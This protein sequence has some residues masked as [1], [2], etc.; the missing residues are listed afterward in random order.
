VAEQLER[1]REVMARVMP[2]AAAQAAVP[3][4]VVVFRNQKSFGP[5]RMRYDGKPIDVEGFFIGAPEENLVA[6][7]LEHRDSALRVIFHEYAHLIIGNAAGRVPVWLNEGLADYYSTFQIRGDGKSAVRGVVVP[8][9]IR[10]LRETAWLRNEQLLAVD[11]A[12]PLYNEGSRRS[13]L[14]AQSWAI[15]HFLLNGDTDRS[16][17]LAQYARATGAGVAPVEAWR[18]V[19]PSLDLYN[20]LHKHLN[21]PI[22]R[23]TEFRFSQELPRVSGDRSDVSAAETLAVLGDVL[24]RVAP[25]RETEAHLQKAVGMQPAAP[26]AKALL[27][28]L[29]VE[30][31]KLQEAKPLLMEAAGSADWLTCY[32]AAV[33]LTRIAIEDHDGDNSDAVTSA[34]KAIDAVLAVRPDLPYALAMR[35][36]LALVHSGD[37]A[38]TLE[39]IGG[40]R[41]RAPGREDFAF[42][43]AQVLARLRKFAQARSV[44]GPF[45][46]SVYPPAVREYAKSLMALVI[47][48]EKLARGLP[49]GTP[50]PMTHSRVQMPLYREPAEGEKKVEGLLESIECSMRGVVLEVRVKDQVLRFAA[51]TVGGIEFITYRTD[52]SGQIDCAKRVPPD[53]VFVTWR[54]GDAQLDPSFAGWVVAVEFLP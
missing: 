11:H 51:R 27:G 29:L 46:T 26:R 4:V 31:G 13:I 40:A 48:L 39:T 41:S 20:E 8:E 44:I 2:L 36:Q 9:H 24:R 33:N 28:Q 43:E 1:F 6:L 19:F 12:S 53:R 21:R 32:T 14:Y 38:G 17:E 54:P 25:A 3:T 35:A 45:M 7:S 5:Y 23:V 10:L 18:Q 15:V 22:Y 47:D 30:Q 16:N 50:L 34:S 49:D 42:I 52:Q 37:L